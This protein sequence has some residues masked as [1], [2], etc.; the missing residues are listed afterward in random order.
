MTVGLSGWWAPF[1]WICWGPRLLLPWVPGCLLILLKAYPEECEE[2]LDLRGPVAWGCLGLVI[3]AGFT[4]FSSLTGYS[5]IY[6]VFGPA[7]GCPSVPMKPEQD[8]LYY[9]H[10]MRTYVWEARIPLRQLFASSL[11]PGVSGFSVA[12]IAAL[13]AAGVTAFGVPLLISPGRLSVKK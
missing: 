7:P 13:A 6:S 11:K 4:Q 5:V 12:Y 2:V 1:G 8:P 3:L 10:C 9:F